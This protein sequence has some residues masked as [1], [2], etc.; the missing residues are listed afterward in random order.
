MIVCAVEKRP[1]TGDTKYKGINNQGYI[2]GGARI[3]FLLRRAITKRTI[4]YAELVAGMKVM[5]AT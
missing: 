1:V 4:T 5:G 3:H 2:A